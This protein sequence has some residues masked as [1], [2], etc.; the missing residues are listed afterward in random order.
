MDSKKM[1]IIAAILCC[2]LAALLAVMIMN[3]KGMLKAKDKINDKPSVSENAESTEPPT[4]KPTEP[5]TESSAQAPK[6]TNTANA[7]LVNAENPIPDE[8]SVDLVNIRNNQQIDRRAYEALQQMFDDARA[9]GMSPVVRSG[10][11]SHA[12]QVQVYN[13]KVTEYKA[14]GN[15]DEKAKELAGQWVAVPG[16]SEHETGLCADI[17]STENNKLDESQVNT[18]T[19]KWLMENSWKYGFVLRYPQDKEDVTKIHFEPWHY[20]Y[21]GTEVAQ[22]MHDNNL[23]LEEFWK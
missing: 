8:W 12:T 17:V 10:Y 6:P 15:S 14:Q 19:Q 4:D 9:A 2:V 3:S 11:R 23:C 20:R 16:T 18:K 7:V 13:N 1:N 5:P 22:Y 21:V